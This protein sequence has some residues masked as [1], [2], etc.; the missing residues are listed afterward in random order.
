MLLKEFRYILAVIDN[1]TISKA[2]E[3]LYISQPALTKY[4]HSLEDSIN[5]K[6]FEKVGKKLQPTQY[7]HSYIAAAR[8]IVAIYEE[9]EQEMYS[10]D[11]MIRGTLRVGTGRRGAYIIPA[12]LPDFTKQFPSVNLAMYESTYDEIE[13]LLMQGKI[14]IGILKQ[15][16]GL[17][18]DYLTYVPLFKEELVL[19]T[20]VDHPLCKNAQDIPEC[21]YP[22]IDLKL[23]GD[24]RFVLYKVG[25]RNRWLTNKLLADHGISPK[26]FFDTNNIEGALHLV[27]E[28]YGV[29][30][31]PEVYAQ[32][33]IKMDGR[34][35]T[36][37]IFS[38][39]NPVNKYE[40]CAAYRNSANLTRYARA[41][42]RL[43]E[44][45]YK[46]NAS[47]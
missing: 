28:G 8:R 43:L 5:M 31:S 15:P 30:F 23:F 47:E 3:Q 21:K 24:E 42:I 37:R 9:L 38:V 29:C 46:K 20:A 2:A 45:Y 17:N 27:Q 35:P 16:L 1:E 4:I 41:F 25:H 10:S 7:G 26:H 39:G 18:D 36:I 22:W 33:V 44:E 40:Y 32:N 19:A 6:L 14:D 34:K 12:V 13:S 11:E